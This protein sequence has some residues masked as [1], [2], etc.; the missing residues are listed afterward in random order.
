MPKEKDSGWRYYLPTNRET[1][2]DA[3]PIMTYSWRDIYGAY[4]AALE[5]SKDEWSER[6]G[7]ERGLGEGPDII[8][9][10]PD[11]CETRYTT[12]READVAHYAYEVGAG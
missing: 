7:N 3:V 2:E 11:G 9:I 12:N 10:A 1:A 8:V 5:A 6:D 4:D